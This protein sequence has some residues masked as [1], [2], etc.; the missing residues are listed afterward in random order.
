MGGGGRGKGG[1]G[2]VGGGGIR[3][4]VMGGEKLLLRDC[5][6]RFFCFPL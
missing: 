5:Q 1:G 2:G 6:F 3:G 4:A